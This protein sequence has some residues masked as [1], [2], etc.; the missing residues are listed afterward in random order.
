MK[1]GKGD[2]HGSGAPSS[3]H[4]R[5]LPGVVQRQNKVEHEIDWLALDSLQ[6]K[7]STLFSGLCF[8][9]WKAS[10][11]YSPTTDPLAII[12]F[13]NPLTPISDQDRISPHNI[14]LI[15]SIQ[16]MRIKENIS[17][18]LFVDPIPNFLN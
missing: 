17:Q 11:Y 9:S 8:I 10:S 5:V 12:A 15:S 1:T 3:F 6:A 7:N 18:G 2:T 13:F 4:D 16:V 14:N